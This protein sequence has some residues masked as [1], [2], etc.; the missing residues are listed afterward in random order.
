MPLYIAKRRILKFAPSRAVVPFSP[1]QIAGLQLWTNP[2]T[3]TGL[4]DGDPISSWADA[5][6]NSRNFTAAGAA[7]PT[8]KTNILNGKA[9]A[10]FDGIANAMSTGAFT[11]NQPETV[12]LVLKFPFS[13]DN[14]WF[15]DGAGGFAVMG[16][17]QFG[18]TQVQQFAGLGS[19]Q[20]TLSNGFHILTL[21]YNAASSYIRVDGTQTNTNPG[22]SNAGGVILGAFGGIAA[23]AASDIAEVIA[24]NVMLTAPQRTQVETY[25][26]NKYGIVVS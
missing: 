25:L 15:L 24:Y 11:F 13:G 9:V 23:F 22:A 14:T 5:S 10:R 12:F 6:G 17:L 4:N 1:T 21:L 3:L 19:A 20:A 2:E 7:R 8:Y 18:A 16:L 26:S